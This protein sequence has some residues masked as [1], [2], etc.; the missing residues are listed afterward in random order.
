MP[1]L[2]PLYL[3]RYPSFYA[4]SLSNQTPDTPAPHLRKIEPG[5]RAGCA[6][7]WYAS[8]RVLTLDHLYL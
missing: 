2:F 5:C 6:G 4:S 1:F 3:C 7:G 8:L